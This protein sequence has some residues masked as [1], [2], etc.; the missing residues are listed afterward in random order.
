[1]IQIFHKELAI[2]LIIRPLQDV[3]STRKAGIALLLNSSQTKLPSD[4]DVTLCW[5]RFVEWAVIQLHLPKLV[6]VVRFGFIPFPASSRLTF[7]SDRVGYIPRATRP[8]ST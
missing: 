5:T 7:L 6:N 8:S 1:L 4:A 3:Y 2:S